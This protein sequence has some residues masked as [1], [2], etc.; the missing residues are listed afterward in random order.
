VLSIRI[1]LENVKQ[2]SQFPLDELLNIAGQTSSVYANTPSNQIG[3]CVIADLPHMA[4]TSIEEKNAPSGTGYNLLRG[5]PCLT[6]TARRKR[7]ALVVRNSPI[8][9]TVRA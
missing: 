3:G 8:G 7:I 6:D 5:H 1:M 4:R 9:G 2:N